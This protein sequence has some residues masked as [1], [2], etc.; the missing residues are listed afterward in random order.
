MLFAAFAENP[1]LWLFD[2]Q[3]NSPKDLDVYKVAYAL[4]MEI[5]EI[6]RGWPPEEKYS[7]TDQISRA[8]RS[9]CTNIREAGSAPE[10]VE[11]SLRGPLHQQANGC[12]FPLVEHTARRDGE[13][14]ET[15]TWLDFAKDCGYLNMADYERLSEKCRIVG[16]MLGSMFRNPEPFLL[17]I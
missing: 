1:W 13:N 5:F 3:I 8:S 15:G 2:M 7:L 14:S 16:R 4:A 6:R 17:R 10:G 9:V 11:A 12:S